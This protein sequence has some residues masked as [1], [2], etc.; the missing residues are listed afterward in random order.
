M[1]AH[2]FAINLRSET[3]SDSF[4]GALKPWG[5]LVPG[6]AG[7]NLRQRAAELNAEDLEVF[8]DNGYFDDIGRIA[9]TF[10]DRSNA[11]RS[12]IFDKERALGRTVRPGDL[13][14]ATRGSYRRLASEVRVAAQSATA[15]RENALAAQIA[16]LPTRLIGVE[17]ITMAAW[18]ALN[19][20]PVYLQFP[21]RDYR[22]LNQRVAHRAA[23]ET[24]SLPADVASGYYAVASAVDYNSALD[25]G[26]VFAAAELE[27]VAIGFGAF[28][29]DDN[30]SDYVALGRK[31][32]ALGVRMPNRYLRTVLVARGFFDGYR[33]E[34]GKAPRAF[35][36]LGLGAPIMLGLVALCGHGTPLLT[37]D[38]TS[39]FKDAVQGT[40][41]VSA[42]APLKLRT[43]RIAHQLASGE[44]KHWACPCPFCGPFI[45]RHPFDYSAARAWHARQGGQEPGAKDLRPTGALF[46]L[47]PLFSEPTSGGL[48]ADVTATRVGHNHWAIAQ[49]LRGLNATSGKRSLLAAHVEKTVAKYELATNAPRFGAAVRFAYQLATDDSTY[50]S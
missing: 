23:Q 3:L 11:L 8:A 24:A 17:D 33:A 25:A 28:M 45:A 14:A 30:S 16:T 4:R 9:K 39:P 44:R 41:Y 37:F 36:F 48:R 15:D 35:H 19:I 34:A 12:Q 6:N 40:M 50:H 38:A 31:R 7:P 32:I 13:D 46:D 5:F 42:P 21:R 29:A 20:E 10:E 26:K 27:C 18:L 47:L 1:A 22:N 43:R 2:H 49:I